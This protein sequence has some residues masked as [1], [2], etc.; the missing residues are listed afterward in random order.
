MLGGLLSLLSALTFAFNNAGIRRGVLGGTVAQA[1][2]VSVPVGIPIFVLPMLVSGAT[3]A[4]LAFSARDV[5]LLSI[6]G[7]VHF[8]WARYCNYR[9]TKAIGAN[10]VGPLQQ[11]SLIL[12]LVLAVLV[13]GETLTLLRIIG[14]ALVALGPWLTLES[15]SHPSMAFLGKDHEYRARMME[16][17]L[18]S[19]LSAVGF[20]I[21][22]ILIRM[23]LR[24]Q[25]IPAGIAGGLVS[26]AA[27]TVPIVLLWLVP[28][29]W[30]HVRATQRESAKWFVISGIAVCIS[31][32]FRYMALAIAPASVVTPIQRLSIVF[33]IYFGRAMNKDHEAFG[34]R[35]IS[36]T[37]I[38]LIGAVALSVSTQTVLDLVPLPP[39]LVALAMWHWP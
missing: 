26:Y 17:Y 8:A 9:A 7:V 22:P 10:L 27:A 39:W 5:W 32:M 2:A 38:S 14:I 23:G 12:T 24:E 1:M 35:V 20:G 29:Q 30:R 13:L 15:K 11:L 37:V 21:S 36:G 34:G 28:G 31:Q 19:M 25:T 3:D 6:A 16:G 4:L 18:Y 33:R